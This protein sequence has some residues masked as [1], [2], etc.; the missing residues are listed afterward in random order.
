V[1]PDDAIR[2]KLPALVDKLTDLVGLLPEDNYRNASVSWTNT[3]GLTLTVGLT[4]MVSKDE[5]DDRAE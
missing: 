5:E 4:A 3:D 1:S 2:A